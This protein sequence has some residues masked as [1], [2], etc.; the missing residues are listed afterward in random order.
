MQSTDRPNED[1]QSSLFRILRRTTYGSICAA[2]IGVASVLILQSLSQR[3]AEQAQSAIQARL[4][5][6]AAYADGLQLGQATRNILLNPADRTAADNHTAAHRELDATLQS[7]GTL[8]SGLDQPD[9]QRELSALN[10]AIK[11]DYQM[12]LGVHQLARSKK[13]EEALAVLNGRE[14]P[15]WREAK[16]HLRALDEKSTAFA[17][18]CQAAALN[19]RLIATVAFW[20]LALVL[21]AIPWLSGQLFRRAWRPLAALLNRKVCETAEGASQVANVSNSVAE[22]ATKQAAS[23]EETSASLEEMTSMTKRNAESAEKVNGLAKQ[24]RQAADHCASDMRAMSEAMEALKASSDNIGKIIKTIDEIAFQTNI[25]A[26]NAAVEAA[27]A[28]EA[29]MGFAVVAEEVRALAQRSAQAAR[30]T[31]TMIENAMNNTATGVDLSGK[32]AKTL[33]EIVMQTR[34]VDELAAEVATAS[35]EQTAGSSQISV[36]VGEIDKVTQ[37]NAASAEELSAQ[38]T[39]MRQIIDELLRLVG[40]SDQHD[41]TATGTPSVPARNFREL[42]PPTSAVSRTSAPALAKAAV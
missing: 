32:V 28:G 10:D 13:S 20:L 15:L 19:R 17:E 16:S 14:T 36:A 18:T 6:K 1:I 21:T 30:E 8:L 37:T 26:L 7:L 29:G 12:Q 2:A 38:A 40:G 35:R 31:A 25:L 4:L 27:R 33:S 11:A 42:R 9:L 39:A 41:V 23:L 5:V 34:Q 24:A 22:G 3:E